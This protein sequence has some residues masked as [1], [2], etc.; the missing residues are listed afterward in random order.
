MLNN[1]RMNLR[2]LALLFVLPLFA[3]DPRQLTLALQAEA[4]F[5]RVEQSALPDGAAAASC[6]QAQAA[7][8]AWISISEKPLAY[9]RKGYCALAGGGFKRGAAEFERAIESWPESF[10]P[11]KGQA[12]EPVS[13][14]LRAL[15]WIAHLNAGVEGSELSRAENELAMAVETHNCTG[16]VMPAMTCEQTLQSAREWLGWIGLERGDLY[17]AA[18]YFNASG[19]WSRW[20]AAEQAFRGR[21]YSAASAE[22]AHAVE[23]WQTAWNGAPP[24][25]QRLRPSM[26]RGRALEA[27]GAARLLAGS[28]PAA[29]QTLDEAVRLNPSNPRPIFLR[30]RAKELAGDA[31]AAIADYV[32]A[33]RVAFAASESDSGEAH[34]YRGIAL[35]RRNEPARAEDE[36]ANALN[37]EISAALR[38]DASAWRHL[39]AVTSGSCG[40]E[41]EELER[42][43]A[44]ASPYFPRPEAHAALAACATRTS[45]FPG[46]AE[47]PGRAR[48]Q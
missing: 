34:L 33:S 2:A 6:E 46:A 24:L 20:V 38:P 36:F 30:A 27:F 45:A 14:A 18:K 41:R 25:A 37:F 42:A 28:A 7:W 35:Y 31:Q 4:E 11:A 10:K 22:Y 43:A 5:T 39:A 16:G 3:A 48:E 21:D 44:A 40:S 1:G 12:T 32:L 8:L 23:S 19:A 15:V 26:P 47:R 17:Q 13:S 29:V 9:Y